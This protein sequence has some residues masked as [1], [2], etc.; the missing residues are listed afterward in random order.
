MSNVDDLIALM[1]AVGAHHKHFYHFTDKRNLPTIREHGLLSL[2]ELEKRGL[3]IPAPGGNDWSHDADRRKSLDDFVHLCLFDEHPM[4]Y[5]AKNEGRISETVFLRVSPLV[6][7][8]PGTLASAD[9]S[10]KSG[11]VT[12]PLEEAL[13][14]VL[15]LEVVYTNTDWKDP[16]IQERR[17]AAKKYEILVPKHIDLA[18]ITGL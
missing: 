1:G 17:K 8:T 15:D 12:H 18:L 7:K 3:K 16:E 5:V 6:I 4:E 13:S 2:Q 14:N 9:V 10:N 11:V